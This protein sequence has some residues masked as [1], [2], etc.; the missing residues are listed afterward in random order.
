MLVWYLDL[1][2]FD[3]VCASCIC[4]RNDLLFRIIQSVP[5]LFEARKGA[6]EMGERKGGGG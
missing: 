4:I 6:A 1:H 5:G 3:A 2:A